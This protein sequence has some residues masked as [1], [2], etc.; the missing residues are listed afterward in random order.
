MLYTILRPAHGELSLRVKLYELNGKRYT[1]SFLQGTRPRF[2]SGTL[3]SLLEGESTPGGYASGLP[4]VMALGHATPFLR[5]YR[6]PALAS[7]G[8]PDVASGRDSYAGVFLNCRQA[9][10]VLARQLRVRLHKA[11][12][13][14]TRGTENAHTLIT[15]RLKQAQQL[16]GHVG[17]RQ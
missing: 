12:R 1:P 2:A 14:R 17:C 16:R 15:H 9:H 7:L 5:S 3:M 11:L 13:S 6:G 4:R 10:P 8:H